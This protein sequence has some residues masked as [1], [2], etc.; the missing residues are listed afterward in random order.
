MACSAATAPSVCVGVRQTRHQTALLQ[1]SAVHVASRRTLSSPLRMAHKMSATE[2]ASL[3]T[4]GMCAVESR[5]VT[6]A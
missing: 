3:K 4:T 2:A 5:F 1:S 6:S